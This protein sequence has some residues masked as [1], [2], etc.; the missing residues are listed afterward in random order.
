M[1]KFQFLAFLAIGTLF[2]AILQPALTQAA[3]PALSV[4]AVVGSAAVGQVP[5]PP[6]PTPEVLAA[7]RN[8]G[9]SP[10]SEDLRGIVAEMGDLLVIWKGPNGNDGL[11]AYVPDNND[12]FEDQRTNA[13]DVTNAQVHDFME[14]LETIDGALGSGDHSK[15]I[16]ALWIRFRDSQ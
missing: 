11:I 6:T 2:G 10:V 8:A 4:T 16:Q 9:M 1:R 7:F 14:T 15:N 12:V 13:P 5:S 3:S